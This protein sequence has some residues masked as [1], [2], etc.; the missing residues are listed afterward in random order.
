MTIPERGRTAAEVL[1]ALEAAGADDHDAL[2]GR[3]FGLVFHAGPE[4][5]E[6]AR[7][8]HERY[9]WHNALNPDVFPSLR[10]MAADVVTMAGWLLS[11]GAVGEGE[12]VRDGLTGFLTSGGTESILMA[13]KTAK[14]HGL[15]RGVEHGNVVLPTSAH[16]AFTKAC[17][18]F[19]LEERRVAVRDDWRADPD[20]MANAGDDDTVLLVASAPQYPQ[21][22]IDPV[23]E[24]AAIAADHGVSCHVDACMGG[25]TAPFMERAGLLG[26]G[27][28]LWDFRVPGVTTI[29]ADVHKY[30]Y[31]PKGISVILHRDKASR[32]RQ[33]F[34]TDGWLGGLYG[35]SGILGTKPGGPIA[36][37]WAV[38]QHLGVDG[39]VEKVGV[40][41]AAR[42]RMVE[43][44]GAIAGLRVL[45]DPDTTLVAIASDPAAAVPLDPFA[46]GA[47]LATRGWH[48]DR[49]G[50]PD[51]LHATITPIQGMDGCR[52]IEEFLADLAAVAT[53]VGGT[54]DADRT[55]RYA[56]TE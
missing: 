22:V 24:V 37:G 30:G 36:A 56:S 5:D 47:A 29:S 41:V 43:G 54:R 26:A 25:F 55:T 9:L 52:V 39:F 20:A 6:L 21:G 40:A 49:Q 34:V 1:A 16:A 12:I 10:T 14:V 33:T 23:A 19:G 4:V 46:V 35:S 13:V 44:V 42:R 17:S 11:G 53:D 2:A 28:G 15:E 51:S 32:A 8:A 48:L 18:Y 31:V 38:L 3:V 50:P 45:G 27:V 7:Q